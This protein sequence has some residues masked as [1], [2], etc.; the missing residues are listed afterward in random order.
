MIATRAITIVAVLAAVCSAVFAREEGIVREQRAV[1]GF[2][3][4]VF[5]TVG[6]LHIV[7]GDREA[8]LIEAEPRVIP[9]VTTIVKDGALHIDLVGNVSTQQPLRYHLTV[10]R[11]RGIV[12]EASGEINASRIQTDRLDVV[13]AGS[14]PLKIADLAA[15]T[16]QVRVTGSADV[17]ISGVV[18]GQS[19]AIEGSGEYAADRLMSRLAR[20]V[21]TGSG[22]ARVSAAEELTVEIAGSGT[23]TYIGNPRVRQQITGA[24]SV[25]RG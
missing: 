23:V 8:L 9:K 16:F 15:E 14:G 24:G 20:I 10:K 21:I 5:H 3:R 6:E 13:L 1:S 18:R 4:I 17:S 11:L 2:D 19:V 12:S 22:S 7:Q 25:E